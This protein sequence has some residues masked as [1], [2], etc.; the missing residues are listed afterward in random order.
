MRGLERGKS[1]AEEYGWLAYLVVNAASFRSIER[2]SLMCSKA[3]RV[4]RSLSVAWPASWLIAAVNY[5]DSG[6]PVLTN[7]TSSRDTAH[8]QIDVPGMLPFSRYGAM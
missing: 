6:F 4:V 3:T 1:V 8:T 5:R 7:T 2:S